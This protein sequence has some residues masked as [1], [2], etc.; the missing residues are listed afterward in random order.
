M[1]RAAFW[2]GLVL[3]ETSDLRKLSLSVFR[4]YNSVKRPSSLHN[5]L[6]NGSAR[7]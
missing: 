6:E 1:F 2:S 5:A 7:G 4:G 3:A